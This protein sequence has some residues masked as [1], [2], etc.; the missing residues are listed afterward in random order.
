MWHGPQGNHAR[1]D[2]PAVPGRRGVGPDRPPRW[3]VGAGHGST[4]GPMLCGVPPNH[5]AKGQVLGYRVAGCCR[6]RASR[7][8]TLPDV[9]LT[10]TLK[11]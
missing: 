3:Q 6:N 2:G 1:R 9:V 5:G 11:R 7:D 10:K 8:S 4:L